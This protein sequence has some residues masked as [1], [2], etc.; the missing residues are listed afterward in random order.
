MLGAYKF[1]RYKS[2]N[3]D[4]PVRRVDFVSPADGA[5]KEHRATLKAATA[6]AEAVT[7]TRDLINTPPNDLYPAIVRRAGRG[8]AD[9][10]RAWRSRCW[11]RRRCARR[12]YGGVLG[13]GGGS[14]RPPRLVRLRYKGP[15]PKAKVAL[16][17]KG[18]TFDT[19]ASRSSRRPTWTT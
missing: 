10:E 4:G 2:S 6:I 12:G 13:V 1:D 11:T 16:V 3:G 9:A 15:K 8:R 17:G 7:F 5:A 14:A 18:I 19:A